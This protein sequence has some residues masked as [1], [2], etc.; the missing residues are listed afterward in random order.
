MHKNLT[1]T[2]I[3]G[4]SFFFD[5]LIVC[6]CIGHGIYMLRMSKVGHLDLP[7]ISSYLLIPVCTYAHV[8]ASR[9][10]YKIRLLAP[11]FICLGFSL[12]ELFCVRFFYFP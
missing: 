2:C 8:V 4:K 1:L 3:L 7:G 12:G 11:V 10:V 5:K 9:V 6:I